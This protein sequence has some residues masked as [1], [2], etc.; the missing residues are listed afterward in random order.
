MD[1]TDKESE[2]FT[3][4]GRGGAL[5]K[6]ASIGGNWKFRSTVTFHWLSYDSLPL[7]ELLLHEEECSSPC[8]G[9]KVLSLP[10]GDARFASSC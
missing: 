5:V 1:C 9:S 2:N 6:E 3:N 4:L 8:C 7:V 10:V